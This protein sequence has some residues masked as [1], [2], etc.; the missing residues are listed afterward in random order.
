MWRNQSLL[1]TADSNVKWCSCSGK[2]SGV[3]LKKLNIELPDDPEI[4]P[5]GKPQ[6]NWKQVFKQ[7]LVQT[8][9]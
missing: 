2:Q 9:P 5:L 3:F 4:P 7:T 1:C 6:K 8:C